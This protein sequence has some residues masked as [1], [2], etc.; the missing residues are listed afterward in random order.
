M[1][2]TIVG[3][4]FPADEEFTLGYGIKSSFQI[5]DIQQLWKWNIREAL[6]KTDCVMGNLESPLLE[7][8]DKSSFYG[9]PEFAAF[10]KECGF[11]MLNIANNHMLEHGAEGFHSTRNWL[12][13]CR[14]ATVGAVGKDGTP[15]INIFEQEGIRIVTAGFCDPSICSIPYVK[16]TYNELDEKRILDTIGKMKDITADI[17]MIVLHWGNEYI[18]FPSLPQRRLAYKLVDKGVDLIV[19]HHSH[20]IQPYEKYREGH[21]FYSLGNF[22]FDYL[23]SDRVKMGLAAKLTITRKK[24]EKVELKGIQLYDTLYS[25]KLV[26]PSDAELFKGIYHKIDTDYRSLQ[27]LNAKQYEQVYIQQLQRNR[28]TERINM[29]KWLL[30]GLLCAPFAHKRLLLKNI[31]N[32]YHTKL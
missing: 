24:I 2:L 25:D 19:G 3:D 15:E 29:R 17:R 13:N 21:I 9:V 6:G 14:I 32:F 30:T 7:E 1:I 11:S 18:H 23:Q 12:K 31:W 28:Q 26:G 10:L 8:E 5:T 20:C 27:G 4:I 16:G 22:C